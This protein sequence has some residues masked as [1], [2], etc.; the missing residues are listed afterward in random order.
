MS[1][2]FFQP[3]KSG[4][5]GSDL[6]DR[7]GRVGDVADPLEELVD[8]KTGKRFARTPG[9]EGVAG[10]SEVIAS[11]DGGGLANENGSGVA[12]DSGDFGGVL[13]EESE[14]L[15]G[16]VLDQGEGLLQILGFNEKRILFE[17]RVEK[18]APGQR[19]KLALDLDS[20]GVEEILGGGEKNDL[21][22]DTMLSL[23]KEIGGNVIGAGRGI[24]HHRNLAGARKEIDGDGAKDLPLRLDDIAVARTEDFFDAADAFRSVSKGGNSLGAADLIDLGSPGEAESIVKLSIDRR[25]S[26][27]DDLGN[28]RGFGQTDSHQSGGDEGRR[29]AG[30]IETDTAKGMI[31]LADNGALGI[32]KRTVLGD[33]AFGKGLDIPQRIGGDFLHLGGDL[34]S[35]HK[36]DSLGGEPNPVEFLSETKKGRVALL[37]DSLKDRSD[38]GNQGAIRLGESVKQAN[39]RVAVGPVGAEN[40]E[41]HRNTNGPRSPYSHSIVAGGLEE[42]S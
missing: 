7:G 11:G 35:A 42:M 30:N 34:R 8:S 38:R 10:A 5:G 15:G 13:D 6:L 25:R 4:N 24:G 23:G 41:A 16:V 37:T 2:E 22:M 26:D 29:T 20:N 32:T 40:T 12:N 39:R 14:V 3:G 17:N 19:G 28:A 36:A 18:L 33:T 27:G 21:A 1:L 31:D 9:G